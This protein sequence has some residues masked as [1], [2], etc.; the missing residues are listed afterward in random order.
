MTTRLSAA[1]PPRD[2]NAPSGGL[3]AGSVAWLDRLSASHARACA[4]LAL[5]CL[6]LFLPGQISLQPMDRDEPRFAQASKQ[7]LETGD[8]VAI[9]FQDEARNKKPVGIYWAQAATVAMGEALGVPEARTQIALYRIPSLLGALFSVLLA[10][11][12]A[13]AFLPRRH[14][15]LAAALYGACLML[16]AEAHLAKTDALLAACATA[17]LGALARLWLGRQKSPPPSAGEGTLRSRGG[18]GSDGSEGVA[19]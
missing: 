17:S 3:H 18:E 12:G 14:A 10:Y 15:L 19:S 16:N 2:G 1:A 13:L 5:L 7:M 6:I 4:A 11:W 9:R 8:V